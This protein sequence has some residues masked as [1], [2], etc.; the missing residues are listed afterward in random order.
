MLKYDL[1]DL[2]YQYKGAATTKSNEMDFNGWHIIDI[3][4]NL[5]TEMIEHHLNEFINKICAI[6]I[7]TSL[8]CN[9]RCKYCYVE[10]PRMKNKNVSREVVMKILDSSSKM[11]PRMRRE[12]VNEKN[13]AHLSAWGAEPFMN[14]D[15]LE[16]MVEFGHDLYGKDNYVLGTSTNG[17]IWSDR[18][19]KFFEFLINDN[20]LRDIQISLDGPPEV[21]NRNR[22]YSNGKPSFD[23]VKNF[24]FNLRSLFKDLG[25]NGKR[26]HFCSTIHL[27]DDDF[28][29]EWIKAAEFF[30]EPNQWHTCIPSLPMR[31][32]GE[33]MYSEK[34]IDK[35][36]DAQRR[37]LELAK[38]RVKE[39]IMMVDFYTMQLFG[40]INCK[41]RNAFPFCS[42]INSQVGIDLDGS[43]YPCHGAI[44]TPEYKPF[45]WL[46]NIFDGVLSYS[47]LV[48]NVNYQYNN[49]NRG[50]CSSC[51]IYH[52][53]SGS[54]C[55]SCAPHNMAITGEPCID[56]ILKC[57]AYNE[58]FEY[59]VE[60]AKMCINNS[61]L[62]EIDI[63]PEVELER[64]ITSHINNMHY[65]RNYDG[66]IDASV[67]K[68]CNKNINIDN[69]YYSDKWWVFD[70]FLEETKKNG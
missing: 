28:A 34:E 16:A 68:V 62:D 10:D 29:D 65:D 46:G 47:K 23:D 64:K 57:K 43:I 44:T 33:D 5:S 17:T 24:T 31:M 8:R 48:R 59:W 54:I 69:M 6:E 60:I 50:K 22:P 58:S 2:G 26:D 41:S 7:P 15:T 61:I 25:I 37:M 42:A 63:K 13:K 1:D 11:F 35:F 4:D 70:N 49:W 67:R 14:V 18:I 66:I 36:V 38:K 45:L 30:S 39:G 40:N 55:W 27:Q 3:P 21:Q 9:L 32:S 53:S 19:A 52:Y 51:P 56:N 20:A 12:N